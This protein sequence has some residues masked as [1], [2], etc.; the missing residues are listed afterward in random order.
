MWRN[1]ERK[2]EMSEKP[3]LFSGPMIRAIMDDRKTQT[4]RVIK[5]QPEWQM[6]APRIL[7]GSIAVFGCTATGYTRD[8]WRSPYGQP[9]DHLWVRETWQKCPVC[10]GTNWRA[11]A[12]ENGTICQHC[13]GD[14]GKWRPSIF[15]PRWASR[16]TL[17]VTGVRVERVQ[18]ITEGDARVEGV[19]PMTW[20]NHPEN[21]PAHRVMFQPLWDSINSKRGFS[22][23]DNPWVWVVEFKR[24]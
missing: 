21:A 12:N 6:V 8:T 19:K 5:P 23:A 7:D 13:D 15:M 1:T 14:L 24:L 2:P 17:R 10:G 9:G 18:E 20:I 3:I 22:W 4:R 16:I 11:S